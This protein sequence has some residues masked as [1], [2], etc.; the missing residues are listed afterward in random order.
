MR[1][2]GQR[3]R[4]S[5]GRRRRGTWFLFFSPVRSLCP[6]R[7]HTRLQHPIAPT[8]ICVHMCV[9]VC[10]IRIEP[11]A[12]KYKN[13]FTAHMFLWPLLCCCLCRLRFA[14]SFILPSFLAA[15]SVLDSDSIFPTHTASRSLSLSQLLCLSAFR[16]NIYRTVIK[17]VIKSD[18]SHW[19]RWWISF[20]KP[21]R[22]GR[23]GKSAE[24]R[25]EKYL[26]DA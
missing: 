16:E 6:S 13:S 4:R 5:G 23:A 24:A 12:T 19:N 11:K 2:G 3:R 17:S 26:R 8:C 1:L 22:H 20:H 14:C 15:L 7:S 10:E 25:K 21:N 18:I 9:C